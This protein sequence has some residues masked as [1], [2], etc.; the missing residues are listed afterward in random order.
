MHFGG[1]VPKHNRG[2]AVYL[3]GEDDKIEIHMRLQSL[4]FG[5]LNNLAAIPL[6]SAGGAEPF[7][8]QNKSGDLSTT[9]AWNNFSSQLKALGSDLKL[10]II[11]PL[12]I[13]CQLDLNQPENAQYVCQRIS[14]IA[15][16]TGSAAIISHHFNKSSK[17][18]DLK[19]SIRGST[20][21]VDGVRCAYAMWSPQE[22]DKSTIKP[23][24]IFKKLN[25]KY[26]VGKLIN[27]VVVKANGKY[28]KEIQTFIRNE[29]G[30]LENYTEL[31]KS[32]NCAFDLKKELINFIKL[33]AEKGHPYCQTG[34]N[35]IHSRR[36]EMSECFQMI[37]RNAFKNLSEELINID[38][39][40]V[41]CSATGSKL[42][43]WLDIP[44]GNFAKGNGVFAEG[45]YSG[46]D[47]ENE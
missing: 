45:A 6:P 18:T 19:S 43:K 42:K 28:N 17:N 21:L 47:Y 10:F 33:A 3:A 8:K 39:T 24:E 27:G 32:K 41:K 1:I 13:F 36:G 44:G 38:K 7:F 12:Q 20:G 5:H 34:E 46:N 40:I 30:V 35:G 23:S 9:E 14:A 22:E 37:S 25:I 26:E 15:S 4:G 29:N 16:E 2:I 11:D 31:L